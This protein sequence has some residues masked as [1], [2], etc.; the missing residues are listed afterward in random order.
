MQDKMASPN[1]GA[2]GEVRVLTKIQVDA[3]DQRG[4]DLRLEKI[5]ES[6]L[7]LIDRL[8]LKD[9][10]DQA[11]DRTLL[12][13]YGKW[14]VNEDKSIIFKGLGGGSFEIPEM[15]ELVYEGQKIRLECGGG[16][17]PAQTY[18]TRED[19]TKETRVHVKRIRVP[20]M[21]EARRDLLLGLIVKAFAT[22][23]GSSLSGE[24]VVEFKL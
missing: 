18:S 15:Y 12:V 16:G 5:A 17:D 23:F 20:P 10:N 2:R 1:S 4:G 8:G 3:T 13:K 6:D 9:W 19:Q 21:F 22:L 24:L 14:M 7:A 11:F